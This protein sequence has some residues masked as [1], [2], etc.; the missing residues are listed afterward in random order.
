MGVMGAMEVLETIATEKILHKHPLTAMI[1]TNEEGSLYPPAMMSSGIVCHD[2]LPAE[3]AKNFKYD[4]M[5]NSKS[6]LDKTTTFGYQLEKFK[7]KG[8]KENHLNTDKYKCM[9][10]LHIEQGPILEDAGND[11]QFVSYM[12]PTTMIFVVSKDGHSHCEQEYS[13]PEQCANEATVLLNAVLKADLT[14]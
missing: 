11:A 8:Q 6:V 3:I 10:E 2:V 13:T 5:M 14:D 12:M 7:Y 4:N 9:F 1:W